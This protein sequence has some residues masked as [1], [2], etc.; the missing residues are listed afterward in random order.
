MAI[1]TSAGTGNTAAAN[2]LFDPSE[3]NTASL[4][5]LWAEAKEVERKAVAVR[6]D[7][8]DKLLAML[9]LN[10]ATQETITVGELKIVR[11]HNV[12]VDTKKLRSI[13]IEEG[14]TDQLESL[15]RWKAEINKREWKASSEEI[16]GPLLEAITTTPGRPSFALNEK[17]EENQ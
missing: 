16:T 17:K 10:D 12:R 11:R 7:A 8:E 13:A 6:R 2:P 15:F 14:T 9:D 4:I 5:Q 3:E 1:D